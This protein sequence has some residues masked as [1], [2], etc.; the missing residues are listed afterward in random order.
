MNRLLAF[1]L[2]ASL[3]VNIWLGWNWAA[4]PT[5]S[6][7]PPSHA[8]ARASSQSGD[9]LDLKKL[10]AARSL[11]EL[12]AAL[13]TAGFSK[14]VV[15]GIVWGKLREKYAAE[16]AATAPPKRDPKVW[17][18]GAKYDPS[19]ELRS[20]RRSALQAKLEAELAELLGDPPPASPRDPRYGFLS[21]EKFAALQR[22]EQDYRDI[23]FK[24]QAVGG[25]VGLERV[26][27]V[28]QEWR[29]DLA[30]VLNADELREYDVR[31]APG[32]DNL[33]FRLAAIDGTE[34]EYRGLLALEQR[35]RQEPT[36]AS[37]QLLQQEAARLLGRERAADYFWRSEPGYRE[38]TAIAEKLGRP[39]LRSDYAEFRGVMTER[40]AALAR[41][42]QLSTDAKFAALALLAA[43]SRAELARRFPASAIAEFDAATAWITDLDQ[44]IARVYYPDASGH[45]S[46]V[47]HR[48]AGNKPG[49]P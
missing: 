24:A 43:E 13:T 45:G 5:V 46:V 1:L 25:N 23:R 3:A 14:E 41:D 31:F 19:D 40:A 12:P 47:L 27:L 37:R 21:E 30:S 34:A 18:R 35:A 33:R 26:K 8:S 6:A 10:Q 2:A 49:G 36:A 32:T 11:P 4:T 22:L 9:T 29:R 38:V 7:T 42:P 17:W 44:G 39:E 48:E 28:N 20:Q 16:F 15:R